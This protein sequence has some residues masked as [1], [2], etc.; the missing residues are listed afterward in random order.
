MGPTATREA[1]VTTSKSIFTEAAKAGLTKESLSPIRR[2]PA[3][4]GAVSRQ[5]GHDEFNVIEQALEFTFLVTEE[6]PLRIPV[7]KSVG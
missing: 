3:N 5:N 7:E 1:R 6:Q 4:F 2:F